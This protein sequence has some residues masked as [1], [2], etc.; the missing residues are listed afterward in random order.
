MS[1]RILNISGD[2]D[3]QGAI[4]P[5]ELTG[6]ILGAP[7]GN[8]F[9]LM[10]DGQG[11]IYFDDEIF[12]NDAEKKHLYPFVLMATRTASDKHEMGSVERI[13]EVL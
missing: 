3:Y 6:I 4:V 1:N 13:L 11:G 2:L 8:G 10:L 9:T 5:G 12:V 7:D